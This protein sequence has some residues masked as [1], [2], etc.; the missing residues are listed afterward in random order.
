MKGDIEMDGS[1]V[2]G[3]GAPT[4]DTSAISKKW[5]DDE[6]VKQAA[7]TIQPAGFTMTGDINMGNNKITKLTTGSDFEDAANV[8]YVHTYNWNNYLALSGFNKMKGTIDTDGNG[9]QGLPITMPRYDNA[10][11]G[12]TC[13]SG[14]LVSM[15]LWMG[16]AQC[17]VILTCQPMRLRT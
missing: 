13:N 8:Q 10:V 5:V 14:P 2:K 16:H 7:I 6:I 12:S 15:F 11:P 4:D 1:E 17:Q 3:L 9:I